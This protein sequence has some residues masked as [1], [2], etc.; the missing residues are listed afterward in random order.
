MDQSCPGNLD[1]LKDVIDNRLSR[2]KRDYHQPPHSNPNNKAARADPVDTR[3]IH[4]KDFATDVIQVMHFFNL[5]IRWRMIW[6]IFRTEDRMD[7]G[8]KTGL[9]FG[10]LG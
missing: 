6:V 9:D 8:T 5:F 1:S 10:M 4:A 7:F 2:R 3:R